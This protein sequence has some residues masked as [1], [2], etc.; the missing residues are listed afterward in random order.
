MSLVICFCL[1]LTLLL[2]VLEGQ[3]NQ[4]GQWAPMVNWPFV[5]VSIAHLSDGR[6]VAW[7]STQTTS[8]PAGATFTYAAIYDPASGQITNLNHTAHDMF[9]S[10]NL[11]SIGESPGARIS[12]HSQV[13]EDETGPE[14]EF[15]HHFGDGLGGFLK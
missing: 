11:F 1:L 4:T 9:C 7:A 6:V 13:V 5:P 2:P 10:A 15:A 8:F 3:V 12:S 14:C